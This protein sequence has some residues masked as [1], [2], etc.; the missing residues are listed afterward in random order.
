ML[1]LNNSLRPG[2]FNSACTPNRAVTLNENA[3][4]REFERSEDTSAVSSGGHAY[5]K[6]A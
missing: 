5:H 1:K 2:I 3:D 6:L 4:R